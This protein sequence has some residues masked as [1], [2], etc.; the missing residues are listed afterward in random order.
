MIG[1]KLMS[2]VLATFLSINAAFTVIAETPSTTMENSGA[3]LFEWRPIDFG[4]GQSFA[5]LVGGNMLSES[6]VILNRGYDYG[7]TFNPSLYPRPWGQV[8]DL[9]NIDGVWGIPENWSITR[10]VSIFIIA[11]S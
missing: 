3:Y 8:P 4:D 2:L 9:V 11:L 10:S 1:K 6:N 5:I 7:Y